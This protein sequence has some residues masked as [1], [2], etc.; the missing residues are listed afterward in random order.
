MPSATPWASKREGRRKTIRE[1][2]RCERCKR[3]GTVLLRVRLNA[4]N[5]REEEARLCN[6][7]GSGW[8]PKYGTYMGK[9]G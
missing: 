2:A 9:V 1:V 5:Y 8:V 6:S 7:C 4:R 3:K